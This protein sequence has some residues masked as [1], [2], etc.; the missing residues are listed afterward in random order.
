ML[1]Q[2]N[3]FEFDAVRW[4]LRLFLGPK[5]SLLILALVLAW[6]QDS[7]LFHVWT[8]GDKCSSAVSSPP[9]NRMKERPTQGSQKFA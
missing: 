1:P 8:Y 7:D 6:Y 9:G 3:F 4:L 5:T 2:E